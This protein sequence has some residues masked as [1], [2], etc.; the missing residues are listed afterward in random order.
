MARRI[1]LIIVWTG[2][3]F[4]AAV[5]IFYVLALA[6]FYVLDR[7]SE[8]AMMFLSPVMFVLIPVLTLTGAFLGFFGRLP[9][10]SRNDNDKR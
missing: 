1:T 3:F 10:T 4:L 5:A 7:E 9:G 6:L 2:A 8:L